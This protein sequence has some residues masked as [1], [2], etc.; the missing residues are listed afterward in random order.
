[1][2]IFDTKKYPVLQLVISIL[3]WQS[4][5]QFAKNGFY[6]YIL[7]DKK[8]NYFM[9]RNFLLLIFLFIFLGSGYSQNK[10]CIDL[11]LIDFGPC[12]AVLGYGM[13]DGQCTEISGCS[14][15]VNGIDLSPFFHESEAACEAACAV[16]SMDLF[17]IDFGDCEMFMGFGLINGQCTGITGCGSLVDNI[18]Y[19]AYIYPTSEMCEAVFTSHCLDIANLDFG[20]CAMPLGV[21]LINGTC[22]MISGCSFEI[23]GFNYSGY[24]FESIED[25]ENTC[26]NTNANTPC[27]IPGINGDSIVCPAN[28]DPVCGCDGI[29]YNNSC[30]ARAWN[31]V[32]YWTKGV[33]GTTGIDKINHQRFNIYP[34]P[35]QGYFYLS[36]INKRV[37][38]TI[39]NIQGKLVLTNEIEAD[40]R[41]DISSFGPGIY[42][43]RIIDDDNKSSRFKLTV[44]E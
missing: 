36:G 34:N 22:T 33:C 11:L 44:T 26:T 17:G 2:T 6:S 42:I 27:F 12:D 16:G 19:E 30:E 23:N 10:T 37:N 4:L 21:G 18:D 20:I 38:V 29:T 43:V 24:F 25:C 9:N 31:G 13:L 28:I 39:Y 5:F 15:V 3:R 32:F 7:A 1:M 41:I 8:R 14:M 40:T 35:T